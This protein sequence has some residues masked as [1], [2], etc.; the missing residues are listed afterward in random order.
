MKEELFFSCLVIL[1][2]FNVGYFFINPDAGFSMLLGT[3]TGFI[4]SAVP[5]VILAGIQLGA[6]TFS[7]SLS[8]VAVR[9]IA[10][11]SVL[12][13]LLI[14]INLPL[15]SVGFSGIAASYIFG[16]KTV[17]LGLGLLT[18]MYNAFLV[19]DLWGIGIILTSII[20]MLTLI[21]AFM[22]AIAQGD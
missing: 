18:N 19:N 22:I 7:F 9:F 15:G 14:S 13:P 4:V 2:I 6:V 8:D 11:F 3:V 1:I 20:G 17:P 21:S 16:G 12:T 5:L 10:I